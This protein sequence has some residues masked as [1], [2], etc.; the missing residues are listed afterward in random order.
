MPRRFVD[1]LAELPGR[2]GWHCFVAYAG[3]EPAGAGALFV[4]ADAGWAGFGSTRADFHRRG[5]QSAILA[6]RVGRANELG[7]SLVVTET[8]ELVDDRPSSSYR[9]ILRAGF[10]PLYVRPNYLSS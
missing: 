10:E 5:A 3:D 1:W 2:D 8:G 6:A 4:S 9:N 7:C